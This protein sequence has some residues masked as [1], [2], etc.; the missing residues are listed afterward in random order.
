MREEGEG[1]SFASDTGEGS[2][3]G[4][5]EKTVVG[6]GRAAVDSY[7]GLDGMV[8]WEVVHRSLMSGLHA[9]VSLVDRTERRAALEAVVDMT[10]TLR[11]RWRGTLRN[12]G[13][14]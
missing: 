8:G 13:R 12:G 1:G 14:G 7:T 4:K 6:R 2:A 10:K 3:A 11:R 9:L 5:Y